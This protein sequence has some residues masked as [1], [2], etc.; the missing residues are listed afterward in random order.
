MWPAAL[1][2]EPVREV[3]GRARRRCTATRCGCS[4]CPSRRSP[5]ACARSRRVAWSSRRSRSR[6]ACAAARSRSTSATATRRRASPRRCA[7]G[8]AERHRAPALQPRRRDDRLPGG[9]AAAGAPAGPGRVLQ[10]RPA[11][12]ADHRPP[13]RLRVPGRQRRRLLERGQGGAARA[14]IPALIEAKGRS[15][16]RWRRRWR[17]AR[18]SA[19]TPT[20]P[21]RSPAS[22]GPDGGSEEKPV[23][24]VCFNAR[25]ADGTGIAREPVIPGGREP[26]SANAR[27]W[28]G[29]TCCAS[30]SAATS[31]RSERRSRT[32]AIHSTRSW[33]RCASRRA[34]LPRSVAGHGEGATEEPAGAPVR[35]ARPARCGA[36]RASPSGEGGR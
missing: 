20:S 34:S 6:P 36:R 2:T 5:R 21:S 14:S 15:R 12:G 32:F 29:C 27:P 35:R 31:R 25:L 13:R 8:L 17:S 10:R 9:E 3:L 24:Y 33:R 11:G 26:T 16:R 23:G 18:W 22:P 4:A 28:S 1:E 19:S 7:T 30:C